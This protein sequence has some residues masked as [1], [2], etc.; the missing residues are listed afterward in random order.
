MLDVLQAIGS[1]STVSI[2]NRSPC[3]N[4]RVDSSAVRGIIGFSQRPLL[5]VLSS[6]SPHLSSIIL[7]SKSRQQAM[8]GFLECPTSLEHSFSV[9]NRYT[10]VKS[11]SIYDRMHSMFLSFFSNLI[12]DDQNRLRLLPFEANKMFSWFSNTHRTT[13]DRAK[14]R[15]FAWG[16]SGIS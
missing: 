12:S 10:V 2:G 11:S 6:F 4:C 9:A 7:D 5:M 14:S 3:L 8:E 13:A 1:I 16:T 15:R